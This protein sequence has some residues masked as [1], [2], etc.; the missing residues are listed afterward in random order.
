M[1]AANGATK[2]PRSR[3]RKPKP[4]VPQAQPALPELIAAGQSQDGNV[5]KVR[6]TFIVESSPYSVVPLKTDPAVMRK[7]FKLTCLAPGGNTYC[8]GITAD[9][10]PSCECKGWLTYRRPCRHLRMLRAAGMLELPAAPDQGPKPEPLLLAQQ[11]GPAAPDAAGPEL[12][13]N[14]TPTDG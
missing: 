10:S 12:L 2:S 4:G 13:P 11:A 9:G 3:P 7:A 6:L 5:F 14:D 8:T 1:N